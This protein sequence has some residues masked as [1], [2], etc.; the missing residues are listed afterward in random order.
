[1]NFVNNAENISASILPVKN[2]PVRNLTPVIMG[3]IIVPLVWM[4]YSFAETVVITR[5]EKVVGPLK[6]ISVK[7]VGSKRMR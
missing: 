5:R 7:S 2:M 4:I 6:V 1:L 3:I